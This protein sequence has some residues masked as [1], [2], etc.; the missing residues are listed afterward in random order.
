MA[1]TA[2]T[3]FG[4]ITGPQEFRKL[5]G[6]TT[7]YKGAAT[8]VV[9][10]EGYL[11]P[12]A[13]VENGIFMGMAILPADNS[14]GADGAETVR[15][16]TAGFMVLKLTGVTEADVGKVAYAVD[17]EEVVL[18][19]STW[20]V[21]VGQ[22]WRVH[23]TNYAWVRFDATASGI[24][25]RLLLAGIAD[26]AALTSGT[27]TDNSGGV[28]PLDDIIA[29]ITN[30]NNAGSADVLPTTAA[31]AQ[32]AEKAN[33]IVADITDMHAQL[34][35]VITTLETAGIIVTT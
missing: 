3:K 20:S 15:L 6:A 35:A 2:D 29:V 33:E 24:T 7:I 31:I 26:P 5:K 11:K 28:N 10:G 13:D 23:S 27:L 34:T 8:M 12:L 17:D 16:L 18:T 1:L 14:G 21:P 30:A 25:E 32:L 4:H 22:V 9:N 19:G